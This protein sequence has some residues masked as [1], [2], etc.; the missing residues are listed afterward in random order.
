MPPWG[1]Q[2][3]RRSFRMLI[4]EVA[5]VEDGACSTFPLHRTGGFGNLSVVSGGTCA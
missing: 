5:L 3:R 4:D 2:K 1:R